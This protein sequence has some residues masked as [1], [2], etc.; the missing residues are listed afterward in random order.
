[1][2]ANTRKMNKI[3]QIILSILQEERYLCDMFNGLVSDG[4]MTLQS[5]EEFRQVAKIPNLHEQEII[6]IKKEELMEN[7]YLKNIQIPNAQLNNFRL[8]K[9]RII[10]PGTIVQAGEKERELSTM[11]E[12]NKYFVCDSSL[13][14]PGIVEGDRTTCWMT[15]EPFEINSFQNI[16]K[17]ATGNV[18]L[19]GCGLG[20]LAYML[21]LKKDVTSITIVDNNKDVIDLFNIHI[22]PQFEHKQKI[23]I[24]ESDA[25][26]YLNSY[27]LSL[28]NYINVDIWYDTIDMI[29]TYLKCLEIE[30]NNP[31]VKFSYWLEQDLK[32]DI[33]K[34][35]LSAICDFPTPDFLTDKITQDIVRDT[36]IDSYEDIY[37]LVDIQNLRELL[38]KWYC[39]NLD[40]VEQYKIKDIS[41]MNMI[42]H[43]TSLKRTIK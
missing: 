30:K 38:Y 20:Y 18:L 29:Y 32:Q 24:V 42:H 14:F 2:V 25:L 27:D 19:L 22:L 4:S 16:I 37:K 40:T 35:I 33:Q 41:R 8:S 11:R 7:P 3:K 10:R 43:S 5:L 26:E 17:E 31:T 34:G 1:M 36:P 39:T 21:S 28:Y 9:R 6:H 15:V 23:Q 13:R 12:V